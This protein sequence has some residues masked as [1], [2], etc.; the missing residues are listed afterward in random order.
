MK[1]EKNKHILNLLFCIGCIAVIALMWGTD[2]IRIIKYPLIPSEVRESA[3]IQLVKLLSEGINPYVTLEGADGEPLLFYMYPI[4]NNLLAALVVKITGISAIVVLPLLN[5][6]YSVILGVL[7]G[8][9][10]YKA[11]GRSSLF[12]VAFIMAH[13]CCWRYSNV[14]AFPDIMATLLMVIICYILTKSEYDE[15]R[16]TCGNLLLLSIL[17][18]LCFF[19]KQY[20]IT[21]GFAVTVYLAV[22]KKWIDLLRYVIFGVII[23]GTTCLLVN[24]FMPYYFPETLVLVGNSA[25]NSIRWMLIQVERLIESYKFWII[26]SLFAMIIAIIRKELFKHYRTIALLVLG[27][28]V[29]YFGQNTGANMSYFFQLLLPYMILVGIDGIDYIMTLIENRNTGIWKVLKV[30][31]LLGLGVISIIPYY[32]YHTHI[33]TSDENSNWNRLFCYAENSENELVSCLL[34][35]YE[36]A[37][38]QSIYDYGQN[39]YILRYKAMDFW[40]DL[41]SNKLLNTLFPK[42]E[43]VRYVHEKYRDSLVGDI[44]NG[45]F[46]RLILIDNFGFMRDWESV[47]YVVEENYTIVDQIPISISP[48]SWTVNVWEPNK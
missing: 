24:Y 47:E 5:W 44:S 13:Y 16:L 8:L 28:C 42:I 25:D 18:V 10:A 6:V 46:D 2:L 33:L 31:F 43:D 39:E 48:Y 4:F 21:V 12:F 41:P 23:G 29:L 30:V 15:I 35:D 34:G 1:N 17:T 27:V 9:I 22:K 14:S 20:A 45:S 36:I 37:N 19:T 40:N 11:T 38:G 26:L 32:N 7:L 3:N